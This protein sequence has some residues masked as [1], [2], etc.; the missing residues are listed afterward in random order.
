[1]SNDPL[2]NM[3]LI[4]RRDLLRQATLV[5]ASVAIP[6]GISTVAVA[7]ETSGSATNLTATQTEL[8]EAVVDRLIPSDANGP[9]AKEAGVVRY[10][11]RALGDALSTSR[12]SYASGLAA[13]DKYAQSSRGKPFLQLPPIDQDSVLIDCETG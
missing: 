9:G 4:T 3:A 13:L 7:A 1:M 6:A 5:S 2:N 12:A 10:I 8:L 11:D